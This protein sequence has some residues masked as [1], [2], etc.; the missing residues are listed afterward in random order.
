MRGSQAQA[1]ALQRVGRGGLNEEAADTGL[2]EVAG[3]RGDIV[4]GTD[5]V[6]HPSEAEHVQRMLLQQ[7]NALKSLP[8]G[9]GGRRSPPLLLSSFS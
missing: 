3:T 2:L 4:S 1:T 8:P 7:L 5:I 9:V 6:R